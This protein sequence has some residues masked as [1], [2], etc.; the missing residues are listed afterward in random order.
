MMKGQ[1]DPGA[2][3]LMLYRESPQLRM[4]ARIV[5]A[6]PRAGDSP[7]RAVTQHTLEV[8]A[9]MARDFGP[10]PAPGKR[11]VVWGGTGAFGWSMEPLTATT[12][13]GAIAE[14]EA[15]MGVAG[16]RWIR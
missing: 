6:G 13:E 1:T 15:R 11:F 5:E 14:A 2:G 12:V 3:R 4:V 16:G 10:N 8:L 9:T 7:E